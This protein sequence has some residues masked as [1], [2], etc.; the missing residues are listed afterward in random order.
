MRSSYARTITKHTHT[1]AHVSL[2]QT[3]R[4]LLSL[5]GQKAAIQRLSAYPAGKGM[6][7]L[8]ISLYILHVQTTRLKLKGTAAKFC[9]ANSKAIQQANPTQIL[10]FMLVAKCTRTYSSV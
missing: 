1:H 9:S 7:L 3:S 5:D 6:F 2:E 10:L 8:V 4:F